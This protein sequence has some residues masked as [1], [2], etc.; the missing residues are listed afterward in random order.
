MLEDVYTLFYVRNPEHSAR[1]YENLLKLK[2]V[3]EAP[4]FALFV[5]NPHLK[6]GLW[7]QEDVKPTTYTA[8]GGGEIC[9]TAKSKEEVNKIHQT[10]KDLGV[11]ITQSP[12][13]MDFGYTFVG[14]DPDGHR[15]RVFVANQ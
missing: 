7:K 3:E 5:L 11:T 8:G 12:C 4:T 13:E 14:V 9:F 1:F 10:W 15:L 2:P 6:L